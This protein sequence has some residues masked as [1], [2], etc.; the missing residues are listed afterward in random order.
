MK[1]ALRR[2][3]VRRLKLKRAHYV[4]ASA[5]DPKAL[6]MVSRTACMCSCWICGHRRYYHGPSMQER[7]ARLRYTD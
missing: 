7:R 4:M 6:G 1:R 2:H 3:H 5:G